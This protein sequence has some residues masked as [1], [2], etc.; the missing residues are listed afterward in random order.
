MLKAG[1][2]TISNSSGGGVNVDIVVVE[3]THT[4]INVFELLQ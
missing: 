2:K 3:D 1:F 4:H